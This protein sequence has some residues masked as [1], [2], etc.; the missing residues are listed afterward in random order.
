MKS[1]ALII[2]INLISLLLTYGG[3]V[4][5]RMWAL[6]HALLD[7][8]NERSSHLVPTPTGGGLV[9]FSVATIVLATIW[10]V[11]PVWP[12]W[13]MA[14]SP[15]T[16]LF[17]LI[18][19]L[20]IAA[21]SWLDDVRPLSI[22]LRFAVQFLAAFIAIKF[23]GYWSYLRL[24]VIGSMD[25]GWFGLPVTFVWIVGMTNAFNFM[26]GI[27][28]IAGSQGL[29]A[30]MG[31]ALLCGLLGLPLI[32]LWSAL[33]ATTC[34]GFLFFNWSPA[35]IF[36]GDVGSAFLGYHF[37][38]LPL[39]A[40]QSEPKGWAFFPEMNFLLAGVLLLWP[41]LFDA[42]FTFL[43]RLAKGENVFKP[44][45]SHLYQRLVISGLSHKTVTTIYIGLDV[46]G[47]V[48]AVFLLLKKDTTLV[49][50][51]I[52]VVLFSAFLGL[53]RFTVYKEK[54]ARQKEPID[55]K[56]QLI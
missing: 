6:R 8:P 12:A 52:V 30:G 53:W 50:F 17:F 7:I 33:L 21:I 48:L 13:F 38:L 39:I 22:H 18:A 20:L 26:D 36:M 41:F 25:I 45:R 34:L 56:D 35:K 4:V 40:G 14:W 11:R 46:L 27:D 10:V 23:F 9:I 1:I 24:P 31:W 47:L 49:D 42:V 16:L 32:C 44:H 15:K 5:V 55:T 29:I 28:G 19:S 51:V 3:I 37:A 2:A 43:R 54:I